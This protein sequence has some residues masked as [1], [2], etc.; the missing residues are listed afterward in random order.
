LSSIN[1][2]LGLRVVP[3]AKGHRGGGDTIMFGIMN[4]PQV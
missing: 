1:D 4:Y 2:T 3:D